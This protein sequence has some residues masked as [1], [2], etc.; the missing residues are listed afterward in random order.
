MDAGVRL[1][2]TLIGPEE[3]DFEAN[4]AGGENRSSRPALAFVEAHDPGRL[5]LL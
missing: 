3:I 4:L 5:Q 2:S 1:R